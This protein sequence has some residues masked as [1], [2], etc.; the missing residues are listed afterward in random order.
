MSSTKVISMYSGGV[1]RGEFARDGVIMGL[2]QRVLPL[3]VSS[4]SELP[5]S[6]APLFCYMKMIKNKIEIQPID[7]LFEVLGFTTFSI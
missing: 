1:Q 3:L 2:L 4:C 6:C 5:Q 7:T